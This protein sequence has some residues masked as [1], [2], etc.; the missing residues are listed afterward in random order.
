MPSRLHN[1]QTASRSLANVVLLAAY[2]R[3]RLGGRQP[4]CGIGV[5]SLIEVM[6]SPAEASDLMAG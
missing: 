5:T 3:R 1:R 4:L 6:R 2:T